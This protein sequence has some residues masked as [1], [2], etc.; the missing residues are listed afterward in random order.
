M[1]VFLKPCQAVE[2]VERHL[3]GVVLCSWLADR[4]DLVPVLLCPEVL[5]QGE[6]CHGI[7]G[8]HAEHM[9]QRIIDLLRRHFLHSHI[10]CLEHGYLAVLGVALDDAVHQAEQTR[11]VAV[12]LLTLTDKLLQDG[13]LRLYGGGAVGQ[14]LRTQ[15]HG[16]AV[17]SRSHVVVGERLH[18]V[19]VVGLFLECGGENLVGLLL[20]VV[21]HEPVAEHH[22]IVLLVGKLRR[23][24]V[25]PRTFRR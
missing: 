6:P 1:L 20:F 7:V 19:A 3:F 25:Q 22:A 14:Y 4:H 16:E 2:I 11:A 15:P 5:Q 24:S 13:D 10:D 23:K 9:A 12:G 17:L 8:S 21:L 18:G